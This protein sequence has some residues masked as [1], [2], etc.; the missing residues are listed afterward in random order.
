MPKKKAKPPKSAETLTGWAAIAKYLGQPI[1]VAQRW[2]QDG[3]P[4]ERKGRSMTARPEQL[5]EWLGREAGTSAPVH[6]AQSSEDDLLK[7]LRRGLKEARSTKHS[8]S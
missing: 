1:A 8:K 2:A 5:S 7:D 4:V 3:M 6:I